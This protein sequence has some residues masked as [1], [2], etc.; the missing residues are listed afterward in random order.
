MYVVRKV[1]SMYSMYSTWGWDSIVRTVHIVCTVVLQ[2]ETVSEDDSLPGLINDSDSDDD[3]TPGLK[4]DSDSDDDP[5][6]TI[7]HVRWRLSW[8]SRGRPFKLF[9][10]RSLEPP[11][12]VLWTTTFQVHQS[13]RVEDNLSWVL[14]SMANVNVACNPVLVV[15]RATDVA[16]LRRIRTTWRRIAVA[17]MSKDRLNDELLLIVLSYSQRIGVDGIVDERAKVVDVCRDPL[18]G[19]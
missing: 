1:Y 14:D 8:R 7:R 16:G 6:V 3:S 15:V 10:S 2:P 13:K 4:D 17:A 9:L 12:L 5:G 18:A 19:H 11:L